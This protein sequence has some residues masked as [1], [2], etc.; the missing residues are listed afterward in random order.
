MMRMIHGILIGAWIVIGF[1]LLVAFGAI[2]VFARMAPAITVIL[3]QNDRSIDAS[4]RMLAAVALLGTEDEGHEALRA[5][6]RRAFDVASTN[7]TEVSEPA[8]IER[9]ERHSDAAF[10]GDAAARHDLVQAI[11]DLTAVNR[12]AMARADRRAEQLGR[13]GGW[14]VAIMAGLAFAVSLALLRTLRR[15]LIAPLAEMHDAV[16]AFHLGDH[17]RRCAPLSA[18]RELRAMCNTFNA[19]LDGRSGDHGRAP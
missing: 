14:S 4:E 17:Q 10:A 6:F 13:A 15:Q 19:I 16:T 7:I 8:I 2:G 12:A 18:T 3:D 1:N 11:L 5:D 9:I